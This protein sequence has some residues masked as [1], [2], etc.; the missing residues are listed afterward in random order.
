MILGSFL[1][2][3]Y[4]VQQFLHVR[5]YA[6]KSIFLYGLRAQVET[7]SHSG[8]CCLC[9]FDFS[10]ASRD[11][12]CHKNPIMLIYLISWAGGDKELSAHYPAHMKA[13]VQ[14]KIKNIAKETTTCMELTHI[15]WRLLKSLT[16]FNKWYF[17]AN[18]EWGNGGK[19]LREHIVAAIAE[20]DPLLV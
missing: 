2:R 12:K 8:E 7:S 20:P 3:D 1:F 15:K 16:C 11:I 18:K 14:L 10:W 9:H 5:E 4:P 17:N 6:Y 13:D 19:Y